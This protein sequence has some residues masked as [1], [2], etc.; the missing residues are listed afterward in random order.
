MRQPH[1]QIVFGG[2]SVPHGLDAALRRVG[3][4]AS[5]EPLGEIVQRGV[6]RAADA[7]VVLAPDDHQQH[8]TGL[9]AL[10][11]TVARRP[12]PTLVLQS[13]GCVGRRLQHP[14]GVPV[15]YGAELDEA[16][17]SARI[18]TMLEMFPTDDQARTDKSALL[19][20]EELAQRYRNQ[21]R[22]AS[23][24]QRQFLP[25]LQ[26]QYGP[27]RMNVAYRPMDYVSGDLY[28]IRQLD[29]EHV[30]IAVVDA[31]GHGIPAA[32]L[33]LFIKRALPKSRRKPGL[34]VASPASVLEQLNEDLLDADLQDC[35]FVAATY[36]VLNTRTR[37]AAIARGGNPYPLLRR[38]DGSLEVIR[39]RGPLV[40]VIPYAEFEVKTLR[41]R[42]G[43]DLLLFSDGLDEL[44]R[45]SE[46]ARLLPR[47][48]SSA[49]RGGSFAAQ[50]RTPSGH[51]SGRAT[52]RA[53]SPLFA[54]SASI[55]APVA[56]LES[57]GEPVSA[58]GADRMQR[59][60]EPPPDE[61]IRNTAWF[62]FL[63][64]EGTD[65]TLTRTTAR[66]DLLRRL[67]QDLDDLTVVAIHVG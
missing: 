25:Q 14:H 45:R 30:G 28:D 46:A 17:L 7:V 66:H 8:D 19:A 37:E 57:A 16:E 21:L 1:V 9:R 59:A 47:T 29:D 52:P 35:H 12:R 10:F 33:T 56:A 40:G 50:R 13:N 42:R 24:L 44:L 49:Q 6:P 3:A 39:S 58:S 41:L 43:D 18:S 38:P 4:T 2:S 27:Y 32:L 31:D 5:F 64:R 51:A 54:E 15:C 11:N 65:A 48:A 23:E 55:P 26:P 67:G 53:R 34:Q 36:A 22:E 63:Q 60:N 20:A 61:A 62:R